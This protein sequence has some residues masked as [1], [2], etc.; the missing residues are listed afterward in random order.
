VLIPINEEVRHFLYG[1][2]RSIA[3]RRIVEFGTS[4]G[5]STLY[6][7]AALRDN[8]GGLVISSELEKSKVTKANQNIAAAGLADLV[9]IREGDA[10]QTLQNFD[11]PIDLLFL[12]GWN[13]LYEDILHLLLP[14]LRPRSVVV[15][16]DLDLFPAELVNYLSY[17]R[18]PS[19]GFI[20]VQ[21]PIDDGLEYSVK[22]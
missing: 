6:L 17:V 11:E 21:L 3:A 1:V 15:A 18:D 9:E 4:Y 8:G 12:D 5:V 2:A 14:H 7:A 13:E 10:R 19:H 22:L 20:S 16:D